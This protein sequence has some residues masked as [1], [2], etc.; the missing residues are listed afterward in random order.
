M[1]VCRAFFIIQVGLMKLEEC[2][3]T[4]SRSWLN[5]TL[6][7]QSESALWVAEGVIVLSMSASPVGIWEKSL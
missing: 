6:H 1:S 4:V 3:N 7:S 5:F 2:E